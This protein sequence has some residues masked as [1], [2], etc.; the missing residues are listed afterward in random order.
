MTRIS[1]ANELSLWAEA[2]PVLPVGVN[3]ISTAWIEA[4]PSPSPLTP[5]LLCRTHVLQ[6]IGSGS[7]RY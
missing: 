1:T 2:Q 4:S 3:R 6:L 7:L 5:F